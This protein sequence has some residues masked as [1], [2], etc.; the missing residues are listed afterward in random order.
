MTCVTSWPDEKRAGCFISY[1]SRVAAQRSARFVRRAYSHSRLEIFSSV[2]FLS[3]ST[4]A[5]WH[6][7][8]LRMTMEHTG[9]YGLYYEE[10]SRNHHILN[11]YILIVK[12]AL[13]S[14][15]VRKRATRGLGQLLAMRSRQGSRYCW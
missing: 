9:G 4:T 12:S 10:F 2:R 13:D 3:L 6:F 14:P 1:C 7:A 11:F 5:R 15:A 8:R